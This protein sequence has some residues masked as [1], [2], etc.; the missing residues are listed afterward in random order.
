MRTTFD[1]IY[2]LFSKKTEKHSV[3][4]MRIAL[5]VVYTQFGAMKIV[6]M[7]PTGDLVKKTV[8]WFKPEIF[9]PVLGLY[10][11]L[12]GVGLLIKRLIPC[13]IVLLLLHIVATFYSIFILKNSHF[14]ELPYELILVGQYIIKNLVLVAGAFIIAGK[15]NKEYHVVAN[16]KKEEAKLASNILIENHQNHQ[17]STYITN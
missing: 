13:T 17:I 7:S 3:N 2:F 14:E 15:Y 4:L 5:G 11:V 6:G 10:E 1:S 12:I 16:L 9:I 8:F